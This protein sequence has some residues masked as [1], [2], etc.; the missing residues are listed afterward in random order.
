MSRVLVSHLLDRILAIFMPWNFLV[1]DGV[2]LK[3]VAI[4]EKL[5]PDKWNGKDSYECCWFLKIKN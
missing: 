5:E 2:W 1:A 4:T 3:S